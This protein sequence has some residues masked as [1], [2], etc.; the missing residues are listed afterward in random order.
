LLEPL[1]TAAGTPP[2]AKIYKV[3]FEQ[4]HIVHYVFSK[5]GGLMKF[6]SI[7]EMNAMWVCII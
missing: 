7:P 1:K 2:G 5:T 3:S 6:S 4:L